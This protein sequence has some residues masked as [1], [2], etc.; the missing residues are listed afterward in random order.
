LKRNI[1]QG[2]GQGATLFAKLEVQNRSRPR[3]NPDQSGQ[4]HR[5]IKIS[6]K[7]KSQKRKNLNCLIKASSN[8]DLLLDTK[9]KDKIISKDREITSFKVGK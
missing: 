8:I 7:K 5:K 3:E 1:H 9:G 4:F 2:N 6:V